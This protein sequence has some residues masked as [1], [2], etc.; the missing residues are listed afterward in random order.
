M[1]DNTLLLE[2]RGRKSGRA[3]STPISYHIENQTAHCFTSRSFAWWRNLTNGQKVH[4]TIRGQRW[5]S[6]PIVE[7]SDH[8]LMASQLDAFLRAVPRDATPAGV[9]LDENG[10]PDPDDIR[11]VIPNMVYLK[12]ALEKIHE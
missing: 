9:A 2:F 12:F 3:L 10:N 6:T 5:Q 8:E 4:L 7:I 1:S 11:Q